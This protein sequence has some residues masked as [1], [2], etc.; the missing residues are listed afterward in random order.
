MK[1]EKISGEQLRSMLEKLLKEIENIKIT[2]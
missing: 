1:D 2:L